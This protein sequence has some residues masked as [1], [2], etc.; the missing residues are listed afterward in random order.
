[1]S[2]FG[3]EELNPP[4]YGKVFISIKP[5]N[6]PFIPNS[7]K[8]N[9]KDILRKY[10]VAGIAPEF[11]DLKYLYIE[12]DT[13]IYYN[14]NSISDSNQLI[15][16]VNKNIDSFATS[17]EL[18]KYGARFKY[19]KFLKL[20][21]DT[22]NSI[23]S[24]ITKIIIRR[25]LKSLLNQF[26]DYEICYGN[27]FHIKSKD[28][29]NIKS[30][31]FNVSGITETLYLTDIPNAFNTNRNNFGT[32]VF[33]KLTSN[34]YVI[35]N[36]NAGR[37]DYSK[38]EIIL[39]PTNFSNT[40]V[41]IGDDNFIE[42]SAIPRSNDVIGLQDLYLQLDIKKSKINVISDQISSGSDISGTNYVFT[43]SYINGDLV[44]I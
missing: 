9:L 15:T 1:V 8:D 31:G 32:I 4:Q 7:I 37:V 42:I 43:S 3:G 5:F 27:E 6:G 35:V 24:N 30:T 34:G 23:T 39:F 21:D 14:T 22:N 13:S 12:F 25:D 2:V 28:G 40:N 18:N 26:A 20:I 19:S 36:N 11:L 41:K 33:F 44:R 29:F 38:G 10:S 17:S 16:L